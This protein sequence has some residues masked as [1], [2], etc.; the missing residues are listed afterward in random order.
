MN[1]RPQ[2][3]E[4]LISKKMRRWCLIARH[5]AVDPRC[6]T[7][8]ARK[9]YARLCSRYPSTMKNLGLHEFSAFE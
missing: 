7:S 8:R 5:P 1:A 2:V 3:R 6:P 4:L 9:N